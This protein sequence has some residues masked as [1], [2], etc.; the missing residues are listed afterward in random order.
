MD[1]DT[2]YEKTPPP[3]DHL[4]RIHADLAT[5]STNKK[6]QLAK[7]MG[8]APAKDFCTAWSDWHWLGR[9]AIAIYIY[10]LESLW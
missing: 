5:L 6:E 10:Q 3:E 4:S 1:G 8:I 9:I 7:K 2:M